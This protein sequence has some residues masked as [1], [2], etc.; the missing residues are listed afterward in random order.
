MPIPEV[1]IITS[2]I[3][4]LDPRGEFLGLINTGNWQEVNL[5]KT[6][7]GKVR[8][9]HFHTKTN[10]VIFLLTGRVDIELCDC[11]NFND[12]LNLS[13]MSGEGVKITPY[14]FHKFRYLEDS[15]HIQLLDIPFDSGNEDLHVPVSSK[16]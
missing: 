6:K 13:L 16:R 14:I 4:R 8:G 9:N 2:Y 5:V 1:E 10:E 11:S 7:A 3:T 12:K 15:V